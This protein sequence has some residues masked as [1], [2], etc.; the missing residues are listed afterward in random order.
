M[1]RKLNDKKPIVI[2]GALLSEIDFLLS[3]I[4][5]NKENKVGSFTFYEGIYKDY[6]IVISKTMMGE[7]ASAIATT[8]AIET[9]NPLFIINQ[10][11]AGALVKWLNKGDIVIGTK[12][13]YIS[14]YSTAID[15]ET[16]KVNPWK[17]DFYK[18]LDG[19]TISYD[20]NDKLIDLLKKLDITKQDN[21][22]FKPIASGDI[23][24]KDTKQMTK[25]NE[26]YG[27]VCE[28]MECSGSYMA[29]NS[30][31]ALLVSIR[32]I[33]NNGFL[34]QTYDESCGILSQKFVLELLDEMITKDK[35]FLM[36]YYNDK[37]T[38]KIDR[39][40]SI[41]KKF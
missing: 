22:Y 29:A 8:I 38:R 10:G 32:T 18:T 21:I 26:E 15:K 7:I 9:Y 24:T 5:I 25:H 20:A 11:T 12:I 39:K 6:P 3:E 19:E 31:D 23:W 16:D 14:L 34:N 37:E 33:S 13:K 2:Q 36:G 27:T 30:L 40:R 41:K 35:L 4:S 28:A 17:K 1:N